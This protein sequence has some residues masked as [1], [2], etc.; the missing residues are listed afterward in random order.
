MWLFD[1]VFTDLKDLR[2]K[3]PRLLT[4]LPKNTLSDYNLYI[5][6]ITTNSKT[7]MTLLLRKVMNILNDSKIGPINWCKELKELND[8]MKNHYFRIWL[9]TNE[10]KELDEHK[11]RLEFS[12]IVAKI[13]SDIFELIDSLNIGDLNITIL[14]DDKLYLFLNECRA[15]DAT[16]INIWDTFDEPINK[17][18]DIFK[19]TWFYSTEYVNESAIR[20]KICWYFIKMRNHLIKL[21]A[22]VEIKKSSYYKL[23]KS[24][25]NLSAHGRNE[26]VDKSQERNNYDYA[27]VRTIYMQSKIDFS[28]PFVQMIDGTVFACYQLIIIKIFVFF[29]EFEKDLIKYL[30]ECGAKIERLTS[31]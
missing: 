10:Y 27:S 8:A 4:G 30:E 17:A 14:P 26:N 20:E 29:K 5:L 24:F 12:S 6:V 23:F 1:Y 13:Y 3:I 21:E 11:T 31:E 25:G 18:I 2:N 22:Y 19:T 28:T 15:D 16:L 7:K 9:N